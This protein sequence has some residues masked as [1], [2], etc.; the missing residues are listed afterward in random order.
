MSVVRYAR[1]SSTPMA[2]HTGGDIASRRFG[3]LLSHVVLPCSLG[4]PWFL[5][6][7]PCI[8]REEALPTLLA[9]FEAPGG[10]HLLVLHAHGDPDPARGSPIAGLRFEEVPESQGTP[11]YTLSPHPDLP[12]SSIL[13]PSLRNPNPNPN[14]NRNHNLNP[15]PH[16]NPTPNWSRRSQ[17]R[18]SS[19]GGRRAGYA[20]LP[21][22]PLHCTG[23]PGHPSGLC[24]GV[25]GPPS[26]LCLLPSQR[27]P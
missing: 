12:L 4:E 6:A 10:A 17:R 13:L 15:N 25:G 23:G 2:A 3:E 1:F 7:S 11:L 24:G 5:L 22:W 8:T 27:P 18:G 9:F 20:P 19:N 21:A 26:G 14:R 16:P